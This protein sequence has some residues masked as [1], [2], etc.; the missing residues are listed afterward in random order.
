[1]VSEFFS[2]LIFIPSGNIEPDTRAATWFVTSIG[3]VWIIT[4]RSS[5][6]R[7][8]LRHAPGPPGSRSR[9]PGCAQLLAQHGSSSIEWM[10]TWKGNTVWLSADGQTAI[11]YRVVGSVALCLADPVGPL[12]QRVEAL[13]EFDEFCFDR[14]WIPCLFAAGVETAELAPQL[15]WKVVQVAEDSII[16]VEHLE[17]K[18]KQWQDIRTAI[19]KAGKQDVRLEVTKWA[20]AKPV[21][22]DQLRAISGGWV[23]DKSLPEM[24]FTLGSLAEA[25]DPDVRLH[26]AVDAD[27]TVEGFTSWMPI[28]VDGKVVGWTIDLMRR[29]DHGFRPVMEFMIGASALRFKEEG[30]QYISLSAAPLAKAPETMAEDSDQA[31][32]QRLL[33]FLGDTLEPYY[34]FQSLFSFKRKFQPELRPMYLVFPDST[35]LAE[36]GIA[37]ARAYMPDATAKDWLVM[38]LDMVR[39]HKATAPHDD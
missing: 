17:F 28:G 16:P 3:A 4:I 12:D 19:N 10:L 21:V 34:G 37:V 11:G 2:R 36:I 13:K 1:M 29:R 31:V 5:A 33:D 8:D 25:D 38:S 6:H 20:D 15:H 18:G 39:P 9:T 30:Y 7:V 27:Q 24:G 22:T 23:A 14:G 35:A 32:L 26:L